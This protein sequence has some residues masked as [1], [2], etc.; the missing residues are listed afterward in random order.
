[1]A[2]GPVLQQVGAKHGRPDIT[3]EGKK[4]SQEAIELLAVLTQAIRLWDV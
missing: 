4:L 2:L 1:M 3:S